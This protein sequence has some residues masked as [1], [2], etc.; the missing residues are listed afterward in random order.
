MYQ[1]ILYEFPLNERTRNFMRLENY[2]SQL[3]HFAKNTGIWDNQTCLVSLVELLTIFERSDIRSEV[4]KELDRNIASLN[5]LS[6]SPSINTDRL[7][8]TLDELHTHLYA[9]Q[10]F[11]GRIGAS[12]RT[13]DLINAVKQRISTTTGINCF[14]VPT[15]YFWVNQQP[16]IRQDQLQNWLDQLRVLEDALLL[17]NRLLRNSATFETQTAADGFFQK[18]MYGQQACQMI[19]VAIPE[20][21][22]YFPEASGNKHRI[23][24][25]FLQYADLNQR[26]AQIGEN[27]EFEL[28]CCNI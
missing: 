1:R 24:I 26:P 19:R 4:I 16:K 3:N 12:L 6:D 18:A 27:I 9:L 7:R 23:G 25:R 15:L 14:E 11:N 22:T 2:F 5:N 20:S 17:L 21:A 28:S 8:L 10:N 13:N